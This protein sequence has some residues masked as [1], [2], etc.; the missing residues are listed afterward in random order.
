MNLRWCILTSPRSG[1]TLL[2]ENI[3]RMIYS[4]GTKDSPAIRLGEYLNYSELH[5]YDSNKLRWVKS[6]KLNSPSRIEAMKSIEEKIANSNC[7]IV[8]RIFPQPWYKNYLN[9]EDFLTK[10]KNNNFNFLYLHRNLKDRLISLCVAK[11]VNIYHRKKNV[12]NEIL[13]D[14]DPENTNSKFISPNEKISLDFDLVARN[15]LELKVN[16]FILNNHIK[17]FHGNIINYENFYEDC[18]KANIS[19]SSNISTLPTY[20]YDYKD[21]ISNYEEVIE[22]IDFLNH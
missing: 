14:R 7:P 20:D 21:L 2:E 13:F 5:Y 6:E 17:K 22:L 4:A 9:I 18:A 15:Y 8:M 1:S 16:D 12:N 10:L 3:Y 11:E 19:A